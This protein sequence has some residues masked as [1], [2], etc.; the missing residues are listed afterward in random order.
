VDWIAGYDHLPP[1]LYRAMVTATQG[2]PTRVSSMSGASSM[3][4]L[5]ATGV[6]SI[7]RLE[8][9]ISPRT[10]A[11]D[12]SDGDRAWTS[13]KATELNGLAQR[14]VA[15]RV[16][17]VPLLAGTFVRVFPSE[18]QKD[19]A[20]ALLPALRR[21]ALLAQAQA[22]TRTA[23]AA[24]RRAFAAKG[25]FLV[26]FVRAGGI[27]VA[28]SGFDLAGYPPPGAGLHAEL[29]ALVRAG[30]TPVQAIRAAT[31]N[32]AAMLGAWQ[33]LGSIAV[34]RDADL[35]IV[36][37]DPLANVGDLAT[38]THVIRRGEVLD[39]KG[40]TEKALRAMGRQ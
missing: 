7:E 30:L 22:V 10:P 33:T 20:L 5:A 3:S 14:L 29:V 13:A 34:G 26:R 21:A 17:L 38:I 23:E 28:G 12:P 18:M 31:T 4:D 32:A 11:G 15:A 8:W 16:A 39:P 6:A 19:P 27:V 25:T 24:A 1:D 35:V 36:S 9:P 2:T 37:G 40:L